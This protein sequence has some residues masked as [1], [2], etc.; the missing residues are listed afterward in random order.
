MQRNGSVIIST[1]VAAGFV[2]VLWLLL[3]RPLAIA[4]S[5]LDIL[6]IML[7]ALGANFTTVVSYWL[8]SS[9]GSRD[10]DATISVLTAK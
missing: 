6:K 2:I 1:I 4:E 10:K 7:G 8:G 3:S 5:T 9:S